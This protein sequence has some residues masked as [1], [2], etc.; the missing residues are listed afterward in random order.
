[1]TSRPAVDLVAELVLDGAT[2]ERAVSTM[3]KYGHPA[4]LTGLDAL[5]P[6]VAARRATVDRVL[7]IDPVLA[8]VAPVVD[9]AVRVE[10][11]TLFADP[12]DLARL[13]EAELRQLPE[14]AAATYQV[15]SSRRWHSAAAEAIF[16]DAADTV[17]RSVFAVLV[18]RAVRELGALAGTDVAEMIMA[19]EHFGTLVDD[20]TRRLG[21][22][23][24]HAR[25]RPLGSRTDPAT[26]DL[27]DLADELA[28]RRS[29][30]HRLLAVLDEPARRRL[31]AAWTGSA[32]RRPDWLAAIAAFHRRLT[33]LRSGT[34]P[35][36]PDDR[37]ALYL[38]AE[39]LDPIAES[40][41][42]DLLD[43][44]LGQDYP[45]SSL[46]DVDPEAV[47]RLLGDA[48]R[49]R[50][51]DLNAFAR[52]VPANDDTAAMVR[53]RLPAAALRRGLT[54]ALRRRLGALAE[55]VPEDR[56]AVVLVTDSGEAARAGELAIRELVRRHRP[57]DAVRLIKDEAGLRGRITRA[58][59]RTGA[60]RA[61]VV[62][63][64]DDHSPGT[65]DA[66]AL[67]A[68]R[69]SGDQRGW[70]VGLVS[71]SGPTTG[72][73]VTATVRKAVE[74]MIDFWAGGA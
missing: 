48:A 59:A 19:L 16:A 36:R 24:D 25:L 53:R 49:R 52:Q 28:W 68:L 14:S 38:F 34:D 47:G 62:V 10:L 2:V 72:E 35:D 31:V 1:M 15:L 73:R 42:L 5:R 67:N 11:H 74:F 13:E 37:L 46:D 12:D 60:D 61:A 29:A 70:A 54:P 4:G 63:L 58:V 17:H 45:G 51:A 26:P 69:R 71:G 57:A 32:A 3:I 30:Q 50:L 39:V 43:R 64:S 55:D 7:A 41:D 21:T 20:G 22:D 66:A 6:R 44:A 8:A 9:D 56:A 18:D 33:V 40:A 27:G 23:Q 65:L